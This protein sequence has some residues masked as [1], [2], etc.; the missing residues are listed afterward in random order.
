MD[1]DTYEA[2]I[3]LR[4]VDGGVNS[5]VVSPMLS[6]ASESAHAFRGAITHNEIPLGID[7]PQLQYISRSS[8]TMA[9]PVSM[10]V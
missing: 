10:M 6:L 7:R 4:F 5:M 1:Q 2:E 3:S 9:M 8:R